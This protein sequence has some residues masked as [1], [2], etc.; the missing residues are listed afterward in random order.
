MQWDQSE[1][2]GDFLLRSGGL[3]NA[4]D[5]PVISS[6]SRAVIALLTFA[7]PMRGSGPTGAVTR[8]QPLIRAPQ[9][10]HGQGTSSGSEGAVSAA[11]AVAAG[12]WLSWPGSHRRRFDLGYKADQPRTGFVLFTPDL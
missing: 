5:H 11:T 2:T 1:L 3:A 4:A 9:S 7:S 6:T 12:P 10:P 8:R